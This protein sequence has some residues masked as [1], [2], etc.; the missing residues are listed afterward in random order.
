MIKTIRF[1]FHVFIVISVL[2][3]PLYG[4][5]SN[6]TLREN[7]LRVFID[8]ERCDMNYI[9][10]EIPYINYVRDIREAQLY[11]LETRERT[12]SGG[13]QYTYLFLGQ[14]EFKGKYD[15]LT[16]S[17]RP[18]DPSDIVRRGRTEIMKMGLMPFVARTPLAGE[19]R[20]SH[21]E[22]LK[23]EEVSDKWNFW[24]FEL[25]TRP[26]FE[27]EE[28]YKEL[29]FRNSFE[30]SKIT[31]EWK[32]EFDLD[33]Y[34][35]QTRY[36][37]DDTTYIRERSSVRLDN[38]IVKSLNKH[39]SAGIMFDLS[40]S[41]FSNYWLSYKIY[42]SV[43]YN[44]YPYSESTHRQLRI[45]YGIGYN[46]SHYIDSTIYDLTRESRI[47]HQMGIAFR[48]QENWGSINLSVQAS[49]YFH[50]FSKNKLELEGAVSL[51]IAK[52]LSLSLYGSMGR[53]RD[54][55]SLA[56]GELSEADILLQLQELAT[57]YRIYGGIGLT[58]TF[59]SIYNNV[60]NPRF[61]HGGFYH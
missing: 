27:I 19:I 38:L 1:Y 61:G 49:N 7:A 18:D 44:I 30:I 53:I 57:N 3:V 58:Y 13:S 33:H 60:V 12:G 15:T 54:Q 2:H 22:K 48:V 21:S 36:D 29:S 25:E 6:D 42:P 5:M 37:Y 9:R 45:L 35:N 50:D 26:R 43:E 8:C 14:K 17:S 24:V 40:R 41:T 28:S 59:G 34:F 51:R 23:Q 10:E 39:W 32:L 47:R 46:Y 55:L 16:Y 20:I 52:G 56:K 31:P 11:I 4:Q